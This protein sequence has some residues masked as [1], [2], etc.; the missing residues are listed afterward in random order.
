MANAFKR[1]TSRDIINTPV[2]VGSYTVPASGT[3]TIIGLTLANVGAVD[4]SC[5][6]TVFDGTNTTHIVKGASIPV[7]TSLIAAG[8]QKVVLQVGDQVK[9]STGASNQLCDAI[10]SVI[11]IIK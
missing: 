6:V 2:T 9:V 4:V 8:E 10:L 7:G 1:F 11:E 3:A 5:S